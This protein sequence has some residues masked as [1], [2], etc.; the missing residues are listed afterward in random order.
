MKDIPRP[1]TIKTAGFLASAILNVKAKRSP[2]RFRRMKGG[3]GE[4][5]EKG[6]GRTKRAKGTKRKQ[7]RKRIRRILLDGKKKEKREKKKF[8]IIPISPAKPVN[9][10]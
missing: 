2:R 4:G 3:K 5:R 9:P 1:P 10:R 7:L 6:G 8:I